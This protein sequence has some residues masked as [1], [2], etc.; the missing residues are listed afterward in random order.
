[1][2][3]KFLLRV[4]AGLPLVIFGA[5]TQTRDF[6]FV[7][8][9]ASGILSASQCDAAVGQAVNLGSGREITINELA[10][11]IS[12]LAAGGKARIIHDE[13]RPG[14]VL[15]LCAD[16][17]KAYDLF[18]FKQRVELRDGIRRLQA[19]YESLGRPAQRLLDEEILRNWSRGAAADGSR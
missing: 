14:D 19:W 4:M 8:D 9:I 6:T 13:P 10:R 11:E 5:G 2:I 16:T 12:K 17:R 3:P 7:S 18:G 1:V 15:R